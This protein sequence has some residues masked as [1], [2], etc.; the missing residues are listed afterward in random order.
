MQVGTVRELWRYPV[1]SMRG[2]R[3]HDVE[4]IH[5]YG[6]P[7]DRGWAIR[8][9]RSG[10]IQGAKK[11]GDLVRFAARYLDEPVGDGTPAVA[12]ELPDGRTVRSDDPSVNELLSQVLDRPVTLWPRQPDDQ[13]EHYRRREA[14]D[15]PEIR[16]QLALLPDDPLP[17]YSTYT[18]PERLAQLTEF[19]APLGTYF[20]G[21]ELHLVT[22][23]SLATL[24]ASSPDSV[25]DVRRFRPNIVVTTS[26]DIGGYPEVGWC[27]RRLRIG[28]VVAHVARPMSRCSMV[29]LPQADLPRD[30]SLMRTLVRE[31][32]MDFGA[33]LDVIEPGPIVDG[34]VV[35]LID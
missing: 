1:K 3:R 7:G 21:Y 11:I 18:S 35:E 22:S 14:L 30:R 19:V 12:I 10:E 24:A 13:L 16:R 17:D 4:V 34:D 31:T 9:E 26:P 23:A 32:A 29:T 33:A 6:I 20:D 15:E 28:G 2:E 27:G 8:N 5:K 25:L